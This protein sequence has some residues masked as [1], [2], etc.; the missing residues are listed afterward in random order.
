[1]SIIPSGHWANGCSDYE[2]Q[3]TEAK[4]QKLVPHSCFKYMNGVLFIHCFHERKIGCV[5]TYA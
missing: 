3:G 4:L 1:M 2:G 5:L